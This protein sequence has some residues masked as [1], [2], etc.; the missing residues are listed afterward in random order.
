M[1][2]RLNESSTAAPIASCSTRKTTRLGR[3][4][5]AARQRPRAGARHLGIEIAV[6]EIVEGA[7][8]AAHGDGADAEERQE[9]QSGQRARR[10]ARSPTSPETAAARCRSAGRGGRAGYRAG[11]PPARSGPPNRRRGCRSCPG[12]PFR[13]RP[14]S[15]KLPCGDC[16]ARCRHPHK[17]EPRPPHALRAAHPTLC[18]RGSRSRRSR[19]PVTNPKLIISRTCC[20]SGRATG[21]RSSTAATANGSA[22]I[23][24]FGKG[25]VLGARSRQRRARRSRRPISGWSSRRSSARASTS[26]WRRRPSSASSVLQP[27]LTERTSGR[28]RQSRA[29]ARQ[30]HRGGGADRA[31]LG[32]G[33][34]RAA[35]ARSRDILAGRPA[36][37][38]CSATRSGGSPPIAEA[39]LKREVRALGGPGRA[40]G[41]LCRNGA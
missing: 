10:H 32:A 5:R 9:P 12:F 17:S 31:A 1:A 24:G 15:A 23:D 30:R 33:D 13:G 3:R 28:A 35:A 6:D 11:A 34:P 8:G 4:H 39:L 7:A 26:W 19:R 20:G 21:S 14:R 27:V 29:A 16:A 2:K 22:A 25:C 36:G 37:G 38:C 18:R 40:G 41:R